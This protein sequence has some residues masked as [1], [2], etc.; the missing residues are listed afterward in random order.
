MVR[1]LVTK[2]AAVT[3]VLTV[4]GCGEVTDS[5]TIFDNGA[6]AGGG[7]E[8]MSDPTREPCA[9]VVCGDGEQCK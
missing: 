8:V 9:D 2:R 5:E 7:V 3:T 6:D 1:L 4:G